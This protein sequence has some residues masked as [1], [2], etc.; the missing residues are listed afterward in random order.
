MLTPNQDS[1]STITKS[2]RE[3]ILR[4]IETLKWEGENDEEALKI[5]K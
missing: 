4:I 3:D 1:L 5:D 2:I